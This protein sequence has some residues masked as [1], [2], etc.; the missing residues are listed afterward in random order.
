MTGID[1]LIAARSQTAE[2]RRD[3]V[4]GSPMV[5]CD[6]L[7]RIFDRGRRDAGAA[8]PGSGAA[9]RRADRPGRCLR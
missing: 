2:A 3:D 4:A 8:G 5:M 9:A 1:D 6:R 7:V